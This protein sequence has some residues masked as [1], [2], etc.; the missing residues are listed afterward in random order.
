MYGIIISLISSHGFETCPL[1]LKQETRLRMFD[2]MLLRKLLGIG[3]R[4][5]RETRIRWT[6]RKSV[7]LH[8]TKYGKCFENTAHSFFLYPDVYLAKFIHKSSA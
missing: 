7:V 4:V 6:L 8:L 2:K 3:V 1:T 5:Q